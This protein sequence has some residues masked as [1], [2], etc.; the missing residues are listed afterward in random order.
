MFQMNHKVTFEFHAHV[1]EQIPPIRNLIVIRSVAEPIKDTYKLKNMS[2]L[3][4]V[5]FMY[6]CYRTKIY[7]YV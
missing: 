7:T 3:L 6:N 4:H 1:L 2:L 5:H